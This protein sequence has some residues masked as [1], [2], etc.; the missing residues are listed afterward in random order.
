MNNPP[1]QYLLIP[2]NSI[3]VY[4]IRETVMPTTMNQRAYEEEKERAD[5]ACEAQL[6]TLFDEA[7]LGICLVD[8][9]FRIRAVSPTARTAFGDIPDLIG[10][11]LD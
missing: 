2:Q 6:K 7:P 9:N 11:D 4:C 5:R 1:E 10:R 3:P 8:S